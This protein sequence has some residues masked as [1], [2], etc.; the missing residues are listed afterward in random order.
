MIEFLSKVPLFSMLNEDQ[1]NKVANI[2]HKRSIRAGTVLFKE[3]ESGNTFYIVFSGSAKIYTTGNTGEEKILSVFHAGESFGELS[4]I[5]DKPRSASAQTLQDSVM[6]TLVGN[7]FLELLK[8]HFDITFGIMQELCSRLRDTNQQVHDLT[9]LDARSR[10]MKSLIKLANKNG[11]R[12]G[13]IITIKTTLNYDEI[14]AMA[15]VQKQIMMQ[16]MR[17]LTERAVLVVSNNEMSLDLS[18]LRG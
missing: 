12:N 9:F 15:G 3:K 13:N 6:I 7:H 2:C 8:D 1:L 11:A 16:V 10:V 18:K 14:S 5:D 4:L 17:D